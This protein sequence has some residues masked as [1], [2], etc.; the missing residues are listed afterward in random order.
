MQD[1]YK[2]IPNI[3]VYNSKSFYA[4]IK[5]SIFLKRRGLKEFVKIIRWD[6]KLLKVVLNVV[7]SWETHPFIEVA[8]GGLKTSGQI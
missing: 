4:T 3:L 6:L 8:C 2:L 1:E 7:Q 5:I